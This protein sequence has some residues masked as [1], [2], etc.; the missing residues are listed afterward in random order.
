LAIVGN[1]TNAELDP[2]LSCTTQGMV[3]MND[4]IVS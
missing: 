1:L 4:G 2:W 3:W